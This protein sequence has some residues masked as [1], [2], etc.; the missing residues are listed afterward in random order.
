MPWRKG[1]V[2]EKIKARGHAPLQW[3]SYLIYYRLRGE[4]IELVRV[5]YGRRE[6]T[7]KSFA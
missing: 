2:L 1:E 7:P 4:L 6:I 3:R 5:L